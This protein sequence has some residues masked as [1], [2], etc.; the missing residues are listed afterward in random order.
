VKKYA[1]AM[2][3]AEPLIGR[4]PRIVRLMLSVS[5]FFQQGVMFRLPQAWDMTF[6]NE[7]GRNAP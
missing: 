7:D 4:F 3:M 1:C 6:L 2:R 5:C